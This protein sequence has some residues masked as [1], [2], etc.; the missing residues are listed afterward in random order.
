MSGDPTLHPPS[1]EHVLRLRAVLALLERKGLIGAGEIE[2]Q[3]ALM[4]SRNPKM[5]ARIVARAW[6]D[7]AYKAR[8]LKDSHA[9]AGE[10]GIDCA[11]TAPVA[12][13]ENS[14]RVHH[15]V[16][17]TLCSCYPKAI[18]GIPPAWFKSAAYR[19]RVVKDPRG[20]LKEFGTDVPAGTEIRVVDS[21]ADLRYMVLPRRPAGTEGWSEERLAA[22]VTRDSMIGVENPKA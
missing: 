6:V 15:V 14:E 13:L 9:A 11:N 19:A 1:A 2:R 12:V 16:V 18:L 3:I 17:C 5:G 22:I 10:L 21:T 8:L 20:V 4:D 7:P